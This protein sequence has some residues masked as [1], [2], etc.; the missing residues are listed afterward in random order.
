MVI[1]TLQLRPAASCITPE[2]RL[3]GLI[4]HL[5]ALLLPP[6][7][8]REC[9]HVIFLDESRRY[10][11]DA[12]VGLGSL[13]TLSLRMREIFAEAMRLDARGIILAHNHPSGHCHPSGCDIAATRRLA[14]VSRALEVELIDHLIFADDAVYSMRAG[15]L[16]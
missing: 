15:G 14:E 12:N 4:A 6:G 10:L 8:E 3:A 2:D 1:A 11:G 5:R 7:A 13:T 9:C 16:L